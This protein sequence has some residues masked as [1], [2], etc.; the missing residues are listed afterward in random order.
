[1]TRYRQSKK[2][3][4]SV[5]GS[6][7]RTGSLI[8]LGETGAES[9]ERQICARPDA[10]N[11]KGKQVTL[12]LVRLSPPQFV[13]AIYLFPT[14]YRS[15]IHHNEQWVTLFLFPRSFPPF[16]P[17]T[18]NPGRLRVLKRGSDSKQ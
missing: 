7:T 14:R 17:L 12:H 3:S 5:S 1:M 6:M 4:K 13:Q 8:R 16:L 9:C 11:V 10:L 18:Y 2:Q 15:S